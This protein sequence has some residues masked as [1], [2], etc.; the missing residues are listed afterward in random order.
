MKYQFLCSNC[1]TILHALDAQANRT[2]RCPKC[3]AVIT[4][5]TRELAREQRKAYLKALKSNAKEEP[6]DA[7]LSATDQCVQEPTA[8]SSLT[9]AQPAQSQ[10]LQTQ[11]DLNSTQWQDY[12]QRQDDKLELRHACDLQSSEPLTPRLLQGFLLLPDTPEPDPNDPML[13]RFPQFSPNPFATDSN[14]VQFDFSEFDAE[15]LQSEQS[16]QYRSKMPS[17]EDLIN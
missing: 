9:F 17:V 1:A 15:E 16:E 8:Q 13:S 3:K 11:G 10:A 7:A 5:P 2:I 14:L 4:I 12:R 6:S